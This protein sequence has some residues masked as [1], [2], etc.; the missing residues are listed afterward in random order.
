MGMAVAL[1]AG[2]T[3]AHAE[4]SCGPALCD[5]ASGS[6]CQ[7][8]F[9]A[10]DTIFP[11]EVESM[12][13][14]AKRVDHCRG[15]W[16]GE[17]GC[18]ARE[19]RKDLSD[20]GLVDQ[21]IESVARRAD[22]LPATARD[23]CERARPTL[24]TSALD[25]VPTWCAIGQG[26]CQGAMEMAIT[27]LR[28]MPEWAAC[29]ERMESRVSERAACAPVTAARA[30]VASAPPS[31]GPLPAAPPAPATTQATTAAPAPTPAA[32]PRAPTVVEAK[33]LRVVE[34]RPIAVDGMASY[35]PSRPGASTDL[36]AIGAESAA[37]S[38]GTAA[39]L[40]APRPVVERRSGQV[41]LSIAPF[42]G[43]L[44]LRD[45]GT[46]AEYSP[47]S[48][49]VALGVSFVAALASNIDLE[50]GLTGRGTFA[51]TALQEA[52]TVGLDQLDTESG[53]ALI[54]HL[55][56]AVTVLTRYFGVG[57]V[58]DFRWDSIGVTSITT[59]LVR[60]DASGVAAGARF[61]VGL[62]LLATDLRLL[63]MLDYLFVGTDDAAL[64]ATIRAE[65]GT[66][67]ITGS[68]TQYSRLGGASDAH[69]VDNLQLTVGFRM[70]F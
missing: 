53:T 12:D 9:E 37:P 51:S 21:E 36:A 22:A 65:L 18:F 17:R 4:A 34:A 8:A 27:V 40:E 7:D 43:V 11:L 16:G 28:G 45:P 52:A 42:S 31:S 15:T 19:I 26:E 49:S 32:A 29:V 55:E 66:A 10:T 60:N 54:L 57:I 68:Y 50:I 14:I 3:S 47:L 6:G 1:T 46:K 64:R 62:G 24:A 30:P 25:D 69:A 61:I 41:E 38:Q 48:A 23:V 67:L 44:T 39:Q 20:L 56:P 58:T 59:G 33:P 13:G 35:G 2:A 63:G 70:V 5:P